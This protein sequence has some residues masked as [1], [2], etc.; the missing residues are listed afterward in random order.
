MTEP[1]SGQVWTHDV[2]GNRF[3]VIDVDPDNRRQPDDS[4]SYIE[5]Q[6]PDYD[7]R[8][9]AWLAERLFESQLHLTEPLE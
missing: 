4:E 9:T 7:T 8:D 6:T 2:T 3:R 5:V 1:K